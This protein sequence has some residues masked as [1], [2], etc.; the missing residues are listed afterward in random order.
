MVLAKNFCEAASKSTVDQIDSSAW[1]LEEPARRTPRKPWLSLRQLCYPQGLHTN[2][3]LVVVALA[4]ALPKAALRFPPGWKE[5]VLL[6]KI[7]C[8][9]GSNSTVDQINSSAC[10]LVGAGSPSPKKTMAWSPPVVLPPGAA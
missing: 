1:T 3:L 2:R 9:A 5:K 6:A 7:F 4:G 10:T 8:E